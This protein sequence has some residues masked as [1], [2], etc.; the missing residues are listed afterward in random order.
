MEPDSGDDSSSWGIRKESLTSWRKLSLEDDN[1]VDLQP[2]NL[3]NQSRPQASGRREIRQ[4]EVPVYYELFTTDFH[5]GKE[6]RRV[7][8]PTITQ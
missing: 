5:E 1:F 3:Q 6:A 8:C 4:I 2:S 7:I